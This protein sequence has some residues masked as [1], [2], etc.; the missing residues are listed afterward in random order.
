ML[1]LAFIG[2]FACVLVSFIPWL[3]S[4]RLSVLIGL[5]GFCLAMVL[6]ASLG[7]FKQHPLMAKEDRAMQHQWLQLQKKAA[8]L[9]LQLEAQPNNVDLQW[10]LL[11]TLGAKSLRLGELDKAIAYWEEALKKIPPNDLNK[12]TLEG[13]LEVLKTLKEH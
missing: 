8:Q 10:R 2:L 7:S 5:L 13:A 11:E 3:S 1:W 6:Y 12:T 9:Q 4:W